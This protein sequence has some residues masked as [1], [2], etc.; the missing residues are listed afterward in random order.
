LFAFQSSKGYFFIF[1]AHYSASAVDVECLNSFGITILN[2]L[3][4]LCSFTNDA[5]CK[6]RPTWLRSKAKQI[7]RHG[8]EFPKSYLHS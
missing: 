4:C 3:N 1:H 2:N 6:K 7:F 5:H 8:W